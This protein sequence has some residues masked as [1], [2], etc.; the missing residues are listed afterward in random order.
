MA[1]NICGAHHFHNCCYHNSD[2]ACGLG[3]VNIKIEAAV[4]LEVSQIFIRNRRVDDGGTNGIPW[5]YRINNSPMDQYNKGRY[6]K[7]AAL[8]KTDWHKAILGQ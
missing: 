6:K 7:D 3:N 8:A 4:K 1:R 2:I 5:L